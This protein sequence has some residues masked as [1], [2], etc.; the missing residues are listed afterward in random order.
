MALPDSP[1]SA[2]AGTLNVMRDIV[3]A[4]KTHPDIRQKATDL[5]RYLESKDWTGEVR[6]LWEFVKNQVRYVRDIAGVETVYTP[7]VT[8]QQMS[9]DCDDKAVL[10]SS[11]LQAIGHPVR[12]VAVG[13]QPGDFSHVYPE[14][15]IG[16]TWVPLETTEP[17]NMGWSPPGVVSRMVKNI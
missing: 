2:T 1:K 12:L 17:V 4:Y 16:Q 5:T 6:A 7:D 10:L 11:L 9:G 13:F 8:L 3:R 14:T 15:L